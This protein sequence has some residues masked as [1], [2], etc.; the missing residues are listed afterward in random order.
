MKT[1]V[2]QALSLSAALIPS[3]SFKVCLVYWSFDWKMEI[4][5]RNFRL[6]NLFQICL[7]DRVKI[8]GEK[9]SRLAK[10]ETLKQKLRI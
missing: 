8:T 6:Y 1:R 5:S 7:H 2:Q 9:P 4:C 10:T 3:S